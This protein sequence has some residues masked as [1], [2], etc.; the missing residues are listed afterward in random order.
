MEK[1]TCGQV[2]GEEEEGKMYRKSNIEIYNTTCKT[3]SQWEFAGW[4]REL[5]LGFCDKL[6][7]WV[8]REGT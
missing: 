8:G 2:R 7:G 6:R 3:D 1:Q 4:L 5:K